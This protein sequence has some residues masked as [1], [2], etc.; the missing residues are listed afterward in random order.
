MFRP[1]N[2]KTIK[3]N[4]FIYCF[5][6]FFFIFADFL[7]ISLNKDINIPQKNR[8]LVDSTKKQIIKIY[9][10]LFSILPCNDPETLSSRISRNWQEYDFIHL[11]NN[12]KD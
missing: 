8:I 5:I 2:K 1:T 4:L 3:E 6:T 9:I 10:T 12:Q 7:F 11:K